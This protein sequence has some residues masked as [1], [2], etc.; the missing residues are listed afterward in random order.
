V[1]NRIAEGRVK[2]TTAIAIFL[3]S[4]IAVYSVARILQVFPGRVPMLAIVALHVLPPL[5]F[6]WVHGAICYGLRGILTFF[7]ITIIVGSVVENIGVLTGF[8]FGHYYFTEVMGPK[9]FLVPIFLGFAYLGMGYLSWTL[10]RVVLGNTENALTGSRV[11]TVPLIAAFLMVSWD[12]C[13]DPVWATVVRAWVWQQG[14]SYFGVPI[15]NFVGRYL[16]VYILCQLFALYL[17]NR[18]NNHADVL[19]TDYWRVPVVF[20]GIS[21]AGNMLLL[22]PR[23]GLSQVSDPTG[24]VWRVSSITAACGLTT[25]FTMGAFTLQAWV[26]LRDQQ[27]ATSP[28]ALAH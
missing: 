17:R 27:R 8:P 3:Y 13:L 21:A 6:A 12:L 5:L 11:L 10:A 14:G 22:I 9:I 23:P 2:R 16:N 18:P 26:R 28:S 1:T 20:Y 4:L 25:I 7:A 24:K 15:S 19:P